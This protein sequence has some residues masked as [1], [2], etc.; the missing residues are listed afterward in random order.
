[1]LESYCR[2]YN[3]SV[4]SVV[5]TALDLFFKTDAHEKLKEET[6]LIAERENLLKE[7]DDLFRRLKRMLRSSSPYLVDAIEKVFWGDT[8]EQ[9]SLLSQKTGIYTQLNDQQ[10]NVILRMLQRRK[11][12]TD[13]LFEIEDQLIPHETFPT[14][15]DEK[16]RLRATTEEVFTSFVKRHYE[17]RGEATH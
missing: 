3:L 1:M 6:R 17:A 7:E 5:N 8:T 11:R 15:Y 4:S 14:F 16:N 12:I 2:D 10:R 13:R 9:I